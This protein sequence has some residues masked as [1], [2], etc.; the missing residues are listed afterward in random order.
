[1]GALRIARLM[2][3]RVLAALLTAAGVLAVWIL[4]VLKRAP[5]PS[6][7]RTGVRDHA[8]VMPFLGHTAK[9]VLGT[10][11]YNAFVFLI[12][13]PILR[14]WFPPLK[15]WEHVAGLFGSSRTTYD[16]VAP[17]V[18]TILWIAGNALVITLLNRR[19]QVAREVST[20]TELPNDGYAT[21]HSTRADSSLVG[22]GSGDARGRR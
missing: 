2:S 21:D 13:E 4:R 11:A 17:T 5:S 9:I 10:L 20:V 19:L 6:E 22:A 18:A 12:V 16:D 15:P 7:V 14:L 8:I 1:M 3:L